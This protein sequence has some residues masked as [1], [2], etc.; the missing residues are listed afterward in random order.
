MNIFA[1]LKLTQIF[2]QIS[3][4]LVRIKKQEEYNGRIAC[5]VKC[6]IQDFEDE[7]VDEIIQIM[8]EKSRTP[9][10]KQI[11]M[12]FLKKAYE[13]GNIELLDPFGKF[14]FD[15]KLGGFR[16]Y[17]SNE[18]GRR[19]NANL[20][21]DW[22]FASYQSHFKSKTPFMNSKNGHE[23]NQCEL[24]CSSKLFKDTNSKGE[25]IKNPKHIF[26]ISYKY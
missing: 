20:S 12:G 6:E 22:K 3:S 23:K 4:R 16:C 18:R 24:L 13:E 7:T 2:L 1:A 10:C 14:S 9:E 25:I 8:K 21:T 15:F 5:P 17:G 11:F 26:W 19:E